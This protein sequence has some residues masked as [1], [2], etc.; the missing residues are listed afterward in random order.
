M[1]APEKPRASHTVADLKV[2]DEVVRRYTITDDMV[3]KFAEICGDWNPVH[4]DATFA[5]QTIFKAQIAHGM[6]SV[7]QFSA[8]F[9][10]DSPGM[11]TVY[12]SQE[13]RFMAP[14]YLDKPYRAV[15]RISAIDAEKNLV[16]YETWCEDADGSRVLEGK[17]EVKPV[18][19]KIRDSLTAAM[20]TSPYGREL[21]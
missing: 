10:M 1:Y 4:H 8:I 20:E 9:G 19:A 13:V 3:R 14:V 2:G 18:P 15:A 11:G 5:A 6:I 21:V 16:A 17:A 12:L 7:S